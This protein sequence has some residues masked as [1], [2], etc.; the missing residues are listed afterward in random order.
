[1]RRRV[2]SSVLLNVRIQIRLPK[3][4]V[5]AL[6]NPHA[7]QL[8][9]PGPPAQRDLGYPQIG[10]G[11]VECHKPLVSHGFQVYLTWSGAQAA[12]AGAKAGSSR[13]KRPR[14]K[15]H[16]MKERSVRRKLS[17]VET[18]LKEDGPEPD[19]ESLKQPIVFDSHALL[20]YARML[21][22]ISAFICKE[23]SDN[24]SWL[25]GFRTGST[26]LAFDALLSLGEDAATFM[27][28]PKH[29]EPGEAKNPNELHSELDELYAQGVRSVIVLDEIVGGG[30]VRSAAKEV[31]QW[32]GIRECGDAR[33]V[34]AGASQLSPDDCA[35]ELNA[36][37]R[38]ARN[39]D[40]NISISYESFCC[41]TLLSIDKRYMAIKMDRRQ[42]EQ[43]SYVP[44]PVS[45]T[46]EN[47]I[48]AAGSHFDTPAIQ[49]RCHGGGPS[50]DWPSASDVSGSF[51]SIV[52]HILD[53][54]GDEFDSVW[55]ETILRQKLCQ[56]CLRL[57]NAARKA[58]RN[59]E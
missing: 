2:R 6:A 15:F 41:R 44:N 37:C 21:A 20:D 32:C 4:P 35:R 38:K 25:I 9:F 1:M 54:G 7:G 16:A 45:G 8:A 51:A 52:K 55:P 27:R 18:G 22:E 17:S 57:L 19:R 46:V 33:F 23:R 26:A 53:G 29:G 43:G 39:V 40:S 49:I 12:D 14:W 48:H 58:R 30:S 28:D 34:L 50:G 11:L 31:A 5:A 56:E 36:A 24:Q 10:R 59:H 47:P 42:K 3:S 13:A